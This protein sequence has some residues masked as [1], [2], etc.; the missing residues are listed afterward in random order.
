[1]NDT[2]QFARLSHPVEAHATAD[3]FASNGI[4]F[5]DYE[6][7]Q[8]TS[9]KLF[10]SRRTPAAWAINNDQLALLLAR[11]YE[12]RAGI[13]LPGTGSPQDRIS[14]ALSKIKSGAPALIALLDRL[15]GDFVSAN[16]AGDYERAQAI[17]RQIRTVDG[18]LCIQKRPAILVGVIHYYLK[19]GYS[20]VETS[21]ALR[22]E[23]SPRA[24]RQIAS[25][26]TA[27]WQRMQDG[28]D[29]QPRP[30]PNRPPTQPLTA[31][32]KARKAARRRE[33][34]QLREP[35]TTEIADPRPV[36]ASQSSSCA[37]AP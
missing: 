7:M 17:E 24:V 12:L 6:K 16:N 29:R 11:A 32:Q 4:S 23:L 2:C 37:V 9:R 18:R 27:L 14:F 10:A 13:F 34:R 35:Q 1:M 20:S 31:D 8:C 21:Q 28:T 26:L 33:R 30:E 36:A 25:R 3:G 5:D 19:V 15:C 22:G